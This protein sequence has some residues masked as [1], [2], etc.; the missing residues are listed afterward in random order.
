MKLPILM[1]H[2]VDELTA[3]VRYPKNFVAPEQFE[4]QMRAL[5]AW[6]YTPISLDDWLAYRAGACRVPAKPVIVTF[7]DAYRSVYVN[8]WPVLRRL[9]I[10]S[11]V[12]VVA[13]RVG[14]TNDWERDERVLP[15]MS[16]D[17]IRGLDAAGVIIGSHGA[18]HRPLNRIP[19]AEAQDEL[20]RS[21]QVLGALLGHPVRYLAYPY[22]NQSTRVRQLAREAGYDACVRGRGRMNFR[23]TDLYGLRRIQVDHL[24]TLEQ[25][26]WTFTRLRW[27]SLP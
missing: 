19:E 18:T 17:E 2:A 10:P 7:D 25:L 8:A 13:D 24:T 23:R 4:A 16:A 9:A 27:L 11:T 20:Q 12:F 1:Y 3:D 26:R 14:G 22:S 15:L 5:L 21:R 6:G